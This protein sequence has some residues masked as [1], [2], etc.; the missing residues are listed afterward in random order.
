[1]KGH[2][3]NDYPHGKMEVVKNGETYFERW[4]N[5]RKLKN[6]EIDHDY[7]EEIDEMEVMSQEGMIA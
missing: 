5:G 4:A 1:M 2:F 7:E 3:I 6:D